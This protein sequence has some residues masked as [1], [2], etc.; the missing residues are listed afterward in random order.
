MDGEAAEQY[1]FDLKLEFNY[2]E[3][4]AFLGQLDIVGYNTAA[5]Q[6]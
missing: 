5:P 3:Q 4:Q 1:R 6:P 2:G